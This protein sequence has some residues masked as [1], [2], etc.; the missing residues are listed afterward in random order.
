VNGVVTGLTPGTATFTFTETLTGCQGTTGAVTVNG[1]SV[2]IT[3]PTTI[4]IGATT[5]L[6]PNT[7]GTWAANNPSVATVS[8]AVL[9]IGEVTGVSG[10]TATFTFTSSSTGCVSL[11]TAAVTVYPVLVAPSIAVSSQTVCYGTSANNMVAVA[12]TGGNTP[13]TYKWQVKTPAAVSWTDVA[14]NS[15]T[16]DPTDPL[17][18][19][20]LYRIAVTD[21]CASTQFSN[22]VTVN[23]YAP[24]TN[25]V[26]SYT[27]TA[28]ICSGSNVELAVTT[29]ATGGHGTF[30]Y[31]WQAKTTGDWVNVGALGANYG[32]VTLT[33]VTQF[34]VIGFDQGTP[35]CGAYESNVITIGVTPEVGT[36]VFARGL[37]S[38]RCQQ[39]A[40]LSAYVAT[41][42]NT[43][44][45]TY[46]LAP[47]G[48]GSIGLTT[49]AIVWNSGFSGTA[50]I[51]ATAAG[52]DTK[53]S[54]HVITVNPTLP[55]SVTLAQSATLVC[56]GTSVTF[57]ATPTNGGTTPSYQWKKNGVNFGAATGSATMAYIPVHNDLI[58]VVLTSN[59]LCA[60]GTATATA[61]VMSV[62]SPLTAPVLSGTQ[63]I[64]NGAV[65]AM[66]T[67]TAT[68]GGSGSYTYVW[69]QNTTGTW[70]PAIGTIS[71]INGVNFNPGT[72]FIT[73]MYRVTA[74]TT[75][76]CSATTVTSNAVTVTVNNPFSVMVIS[77]AQTICNGSVPA[78]LTSAGTT[79]GS[80]TFSYQ[81]QKTT[82]GTNWTN[83]G[84]NSLT[85]ASPALTLTTTFRLI[86][87]DTGTPS[88][89]AVYSNNLVVTV[90]TAIT[91]GSI[92]INQVNSVPFHTEIIN[93][94]LGTGGTSYKWQAGDSET[95]PW[96]DV[97][98]ATGTDYD[99]GVT[100]A[101]A[102]YRRVTVLTQ[103]SIV[104]TVA[105]AAVKVT[106]TILVHA[107][108][109]LEGAW[110]GSS[111]N[112]GLAI[113]TAQPYNVAPW[114]LVQAGVTAVPTGVVDWVLVEIRHAM[115]PAAATGTTVLAKRAAFLM[116][117]GTIVDPD[118]TLS[119]DVRFDNAVLPAGENLYIVIRH[120]NHL[121]I[122]SATG[123]AVTA[124]V[125][126]YD[127]RTS[128]SQAYG[129]V[130]SYKLVGT[131]PVMIAGDIDHDGQVAPSDWNIW[132]T[133]FG[134]SGY[135]ASDLDMNGSVSVTDWNKWAANYGSSIDN[136]IKAGKLVK[137]FSSVPQ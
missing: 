113:P 66:L 64:C 93:V 100:P 6:S 57:T 133:E 87:T 88:C 70:V 122:M 39:D 9:H 3:G 48:A 68:S 115:T 119:N 33:E 10:G 108:V 109:N 42:T 110:N 50:T 53:T 51:T 27:G 137:Y 95:G 52:C 125:Y 41:A 136:G 49:G 35:S 21:A 16:Y 1:N 74:S 131:V 38:V 2:S 55:V 130:N 77:A 19:T 106:A 107:E 46:A 81:W 105:T 112:T 17:T 116:S 75:G 28:T 34:R 99:P 111:M 128:L 44:G 102:W 90:N 31:Q 61:T 76:P 13:Y 12:A 117:D 124:G 94:T 101:S 84:T 62:N 132:V 114:N 20:M 60:S 65:A 135:K 96:T 24:L 18:A 7:G 126:H 5:T 69:E 15:L 67:R 85:Y 32:P 47:A 40:A 72:L 58:S 4:C 29:V 25:P 30:T 14:V 134:T 123:A 97:L 11:P 45:I 79:G 63:T 73:T 82:D 22:T 36:P 91:A 59:A 104:C 86:A 121:A 89:G 37:T 120:R 8:N 118:P 23:T 54:T 83:V 56:A 92:R 127:F 78:A 103:N 71:G 80:G 26:I 43:S 129:P 98:G